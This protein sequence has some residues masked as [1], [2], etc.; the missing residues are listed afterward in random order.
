LKLYAKIILFAVISASGSFI[1]VV[2]QEKKSAPP[3]LKPEVALALRSSQFAQA[4]TLLQMKELE[5]QYAQLQ[6]Q[7]T[8]AQADFKTKLDTA[9]K[10]SGIDP[11]KYAVDP[12]TL[13][14]TEKPK[15]PAK[16]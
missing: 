5:R 12:D 3:T 15:P 11:E 1:G 8:V 14:V 6:Q 10:D 2:S 13:A 9:L 7:L 16:P 4:K